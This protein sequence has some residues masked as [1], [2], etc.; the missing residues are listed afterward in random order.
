MA[1]GLGPHQGLAAQHAALPQPH[2]ELAQQLLQH[3][4]LLPGVPAAGA[5]QVRAH[6]E[7]RHIQVAVGQRQPRR[8]AAKEHLRMARSVFEK[9]RCGPTP[10]TAAPRS[11][12]GSASSVAWPPTQAAE[13]PSNIT[14]PCGKAQPRCLCRQDLMQPY[15]TLQWFPIMRTVRLPGQSSLAA[16]PTIHSV[17]RICAASA[18][19][20]AAA[21]AKRSTSPCSADSRRAGARPPASSPGGPPGAVSGISPRRNPGSAPVPGPG[22][23]VRSSPGGPSSPTPGPTPGKLLAP[24]GAPRRLRTRSVARR[25]RSRLRASH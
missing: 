17:S 2:S 14:P 20:G 10:S 21:A 12:S 11:L 9:C 1:A 6:A 18:G 25:L 22:G 4:A 16:A 13:I 15:T 3:A 8:L 19:V 7:H 24:L 23:S 5:R